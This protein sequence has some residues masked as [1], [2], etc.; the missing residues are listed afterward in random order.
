MRAAALAA[1]D[2]D[3]EMDSQRPLA[4][5]G[6]EH[7]PAARSCRRLAASWSA[8]PEVPLIV[9]VDRSAPVHDIIIRY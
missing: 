1:S 2:I 9:A 3:S 5:A 8:G 4:L 7:L 6:W